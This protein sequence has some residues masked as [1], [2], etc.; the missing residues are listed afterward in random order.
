MKQAVLVSACCLFHAGFLLALLFTPE[1]GDDIFVLNVSSFSPDHTEYSTLHSLY[2]TNIKP[3]IR[4][5]Y[6][7]KTFIDRAFIILLYILHLNTHT[8]IIIT[9]H[10]IQSSTHKTNVHVYYKFKCFLHKVTVKHKVQNLSSSGQ[11]YS[12][13][14]PYSSFARYNFHALTFIFN[15]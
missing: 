15:I 11:Y 3:N 5:D 6:F 8:F 9:V 1:H 4:Y 12:T 14:S 10:K 2:C 13:P 7:V